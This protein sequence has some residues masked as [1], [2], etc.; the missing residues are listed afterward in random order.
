MPRS[1][2]QALR[3]FAALR[4]A[5]WIDRELARLCFRLG[6]IDR[7]EAHLARARRRFIK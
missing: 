1:G 4:R 5:A 6:D 3:L 7:A 2:G